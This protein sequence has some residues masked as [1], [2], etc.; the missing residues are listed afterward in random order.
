MRF[1]RLEIDGFKSFGMPVTFD[2][3]PGIVG[4]VGPNGSGKSNIVDAVRWLFGERANSKLRMSDGPDVLYVGSNKR[5]DRASVKAIFRNETKDISIERVYS[6]GKNV[7]MMNGSQTR[8]KDI[9]AVFMGTGTGRD[10]YSI[11]GQGEI[12]QLVSSSPEQIKTLVEEA[13]GVAVYKIKKN[14]T[15]GKLSH[16]QENLDRLRDVMNEVERTMRSLNLKSKRALKY[17]EYETELNSRKRKYF[18]HHF[19]VNSEKLNVLSGKT[20]EISDG[21]RRLQKE[22][23][24]LETQTSE[25]KDLTSGAEEEIRKFENEL[26]RYR[27]REKTLSELK[28][29]YSSK[30][31]SSRASHVELGTKKDSMNAELERSTE[32]LEELKRIIGSLEKEEGEISLKLKEAEGSYSTLVEE[33]GKSEKKRA[34]IENRLSRLTKERN[35]IEVEISKASENT[36]DLTQRLAVLVDQIKEKTD[37]AAELQK[38]LDEVDFEESK[39][40]ATVEQHNKELEAMDEK[41][42]KIDSKVSETRNKRESLNSKILELKSRHEILVRNM[43]S[44]A[45]YSGA[46]RAVMGAKAKGVIDVVANLIDVPRDIE[47]AVSVILGG[48]TQFVVVDNAQ[49]AKECV[50]LLKRSGA[51]R[52]TFIPMDTV[53]LREP[54]IQTSI[55]FAPGVVGYAFKL[56]KAVKG[57]ERL[58][59]FLFREDLIVETLDHAIALRKNKNVNSRIVSLDGQLLA[60]AG[61]IT[62]GSAERTDLVSHRRTLKDLESEILDRT[63]ELKKFDADI[64]QLEVRR[65]ILIKEKADLERAIL[66]ESVSLN[67]SRGVKSNLLAQLASLQKEV[68][69]LNKFKEDYTKRIQRYEKI[70]SESGEKIVAIDLELKE[71]EE[72]L[73]DD[74]TE[75]LRKRQELE[76][77]QEEMIDLKMG[78]NSIRERLSGYT[79]ESARI[80]GRVEEVRIEL[81][82]IKSKL[83]KVSVEIG[84]V[85]E[86][87]KVVDRDLGSVQTDIETLFNRSKNTKGNRDETLKNLERLET[88]SKK[89]RKELEVFRES[90]HNFEIEKVSIESAIE[91]AVNE[92]VEAGGTKEETVSLDDETVKTLSSEIEEYER[93][94]KFLGPVD[95]SAIEEY[96]KTSERYDDLSLQKTDLESS[97]ASLEEVIMKTDEEARTLLIRTLDRINENFERMIS[98]LFSDGNGKLS[99]VEGADVLESPVEIKVKLPGKKIQK[100]YMLS[101]G[102]KSL[103]GLAF[104]FSLLMIN[105]S[106]FYILDEVDAALDDFSTQRFIN[107][108]SEYSK[109]AT[110]LIMT[111]NKIVMEGADTLYGVTMINGVST[112]IP[113][114]LSEFSTTGTEG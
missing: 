63:E 1:V 24:E 78:L 41:R 102:E 80:T 109:R 42:R 89:K 79:N 99:F 12:A 84:E 50:E 15:L 26:E 7:Y 88:T 56:V 47:M 51:G 4:I 91:N 101:G 49:V 36:K 112:V 98:I 77:V 54:S 27:E 90:L 16:V 75:N 25:L 22:L 8:L 21:I 28:E 53:N 31:S 68:N 32:R 20:A 97:Y 71:L 38:E 43:E 96:E 110:F 19:S 107:L 44:Y 105:P 18:G 34:E 5:A 103:V 111:H 70:S 40:L 45:G 33:M 3:K 85:R 94:L 93:K 39:V 29:M 76:K 57:Y 6:D 61:T 23:F 106:P 14:E 58:T 92:L 72:H 2:I 64:G 114:E 11:V 104:I 13:A 67:N 10:L 9:E 37:K 87:L 113:V 83:E 74:S 35:S 86:H 60:P 46:V 69:D 82:E 108:L 95:L 66:K 62:G 100:L 55:V 65:E 52:A 30:L 17:R 81:S 59:N 48:R 73:R